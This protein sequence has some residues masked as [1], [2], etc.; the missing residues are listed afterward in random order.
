MYRKCKRVAVVM[1][2]I[3][4]MFSILTT[5]VFAA[6]PYE[7]YTYTEWSTSVPTPESYVPTNTYTGSQMGTTNFKEPG[8]FCFGPDGR[9]YV[10]DSGNNRVVVFDSDMKFVKEYTSFTDPKAVGQQQAVVGLM[11]LY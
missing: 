8:D 5:G 2:T 9:L 3:L 1:V 4:M 6:T 11:V 7:N 10:L